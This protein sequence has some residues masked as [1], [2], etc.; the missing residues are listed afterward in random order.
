MISREEAL[1]RARSWAAQSRPGQAPE[2]GLY[3]FDLGYVV[4]R[5]SGQPAARTTAPEAGEPRMVIDRETG[6]MTSWPSLSAPMV[7]DQYT[8]YHAAEHRF[9]PDV[10]FVLTEAGWFPGRD[11]SASVNL[12]LK[13]HAEKLDG[14]EPTPAALAALNE[15]G[16][17]QLPQFGRNGEAG[18]GYTSYLHPTGGGVGTR[19]AHTFAE[20]FEDPVFPLGNNEDG[21]SELVID[22]QGRVFMLHWA[23]DLFVGPNIDAALVALV[24]GT[25]L[26]P[27][28]ETTW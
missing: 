22:A 1:S 5:V 20:D 7:A 2:V 18:A 8:K 13:E 6:E 17:L 3:E 14:L 15:F 27:A 21:P 24:R 23:N 25:E 4:W 19:A 16:G 12:W 26:V 11:V 9:P 10:R 28:D